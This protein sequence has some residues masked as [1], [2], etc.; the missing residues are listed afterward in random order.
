MLGDEKCGRSTLLHFLTT[1]RYE[2]FIAEQAL[3]YTQL[4]FEQDELLFYDIPAQTL[5][6]S[7]PN[8]HF[9]DTK[10][11]IITV[12]AT[13]ASTWTLAEEFHRKVLAYIARLPSTQKP[14]IMILLTKCDSPERELADVSI[15][16]HSKQLM[17]NAVFYL[18][19]KANWNVKHFIPTVHALAS[20]QQKTPIALNVFPIVKNP[21][22]FNSFITVY[23]IDVSQVLT[24]KM[25]K[26]Q[27]K[28]ASAVR[29]CGAIVIALNCEPVH[30]R[31]IT[32]VQLIEMAGQQG[33]QAIVETPE[34]KLG[35]KTLALSMLEDIGEILK[36]NLVYY[37]PIH[38]A[39]TSHAL[40]GTL[41]KRHQKNDCAVM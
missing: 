34:F 14:A 32:A 16:Q 29:Q 18:S 17:P 20:V 23:L 2:E 11:F 26:Q 25:F 1:G 35:K 8:E 27:F 36:T 15:L 9:A 22:G 33:C 30:A 19:T 41:K 24:E 10:L 4:A 3:V 5:R 7:D 38:G 39:R 31:K 21:N 37:Y 40:Q 6:T 28:P 13:R 12:D